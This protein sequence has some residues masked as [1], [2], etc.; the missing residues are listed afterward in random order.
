MSVAVAT[1]P[2]TGEGLAARRALRDARIRGIAF[3]V[4]AVLAVAFAFHETVKPTG[5]VNGFGIAATFQFWVHERGGDAVTIQTTV[6]LMW[7]IAAIGSAIVAVL[8]FVGG[9]AF[10]WRRWLALVIAPWIAA[11]L[12]NILDGKTAT[13]TNVIGGS[14]ELA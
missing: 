11:L 2:I 13:L 14:L 1:A 5:T 4:L 12:A 7:M 8:Q 9:A 10:R 3:A 6:G